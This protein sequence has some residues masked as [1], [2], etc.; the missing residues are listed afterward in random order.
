MCS[1]AIVHRLLGGQ[2]VVIREDCLSGTAPSSGCHGDVIL[3]EAGGWLL[4]AAM[5][6]RAEVTDA[7]QEVPTNWHG[8]KRQV[9]ELSTGTVNSLGHERRNSEHGYMRGDQ[10]PSGR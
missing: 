10:E 2:R 8:L 4:T 3:S 9:S 1:A 5:S 6:V 7:P